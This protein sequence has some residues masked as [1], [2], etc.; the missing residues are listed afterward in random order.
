M[1]LTA[2]QHVRGQ[3]KIGLVVTARTSPFMN[4]VRR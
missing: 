1:M 2:R 4:A 3:N